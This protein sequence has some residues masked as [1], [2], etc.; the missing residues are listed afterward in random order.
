[1]KFSEY[2]EGVEKYD[3]NDHL[4]GHD[5]EG[6]VELVGGNH[7]LVPKVQRDGTGSIEHRHGDGF[8]L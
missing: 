7:S 5:E 8:Q 1:L 6:V 4:Q 3:C 2:S